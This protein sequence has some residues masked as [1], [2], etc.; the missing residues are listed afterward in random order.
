LDRCTT[1]SFAPE[2]QYPFIYKPL[3]VLFP[4]YPLPPKI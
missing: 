1:S 2:R 3:A 4:T